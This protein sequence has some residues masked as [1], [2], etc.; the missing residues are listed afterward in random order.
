MLAS[1][2]SN[3]PATEGGQ[4]LCLE[5]PYE[6]PSCYGGHARIATLCK[7]EKAKNANTLCID[8]GDEFLGTAW[9]IIFQGQQN[10]EVLGAVGTDVMVV[11][12]HEFDYGAPPAACMRLRR[13]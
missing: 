9:D 13:K 2:C 3:T 5:D 11:G 8:G 12:N 7:A 10:V 1:T 4:Q 6:D